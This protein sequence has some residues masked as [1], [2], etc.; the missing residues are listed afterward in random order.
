[1][2][3]FLAQAVIFFLI[4]FLGVIGNSIVLYVL[5]KQ[6]GSWSITTTYLFNLA[7]ADT[8]FVCILPFWGHYHLKG[9]D[10]NFGTAMCKAAGT[11]T[12]LNMYASIFFLT[13]MSADRWMAI[14]HA[15]RMNQRRNSM[16]TRRICVGIWFVSL[17]LC[18]PSIIFRKVLYMPHHGSN[19]TTEE[20]NGTVSDNKTFTNFCGL[21]I[22][23][24]V[25]SKFTIMGTTEFLRSLLGFFLPLCTICFCYI[26]IVRTVKRKVINRRVRKDK[27]ATLAGFVIGAFIFCWT[28]YHVI[29]LYSAL[30]G[31]W[32]IFPVDPCFYNAV[33]PFTVC[34]AYANSCINPIVYAFTTTKFQE[35]MRDICAADK[36]PRPYRMVLST[37][38]H[39]K[40]GRDYTLQGNSS[41]RNKKKTQNEV[42][43]VLQDKV[44]IILAL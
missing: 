38:N 2:T 12:Y 5:L 29:N 41:A 31:W 11:I 21:F 7:I 16:Y 4:F 19:C 17:I 30:G 22:P 37:R 33:K 34:L 40:S 1:M 10:W 15:T 8:L 32:E 9:L 36:S 24:E 25:N 39:G 35:N 44:I 27:V 23:K 42:E 43:V 6:K 26:N 3:V 18:L 20:Y 13:A 28:P 14:V